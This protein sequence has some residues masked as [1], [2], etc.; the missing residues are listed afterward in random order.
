[1]EGES[2]VQGVQAD[3]ETYSHQRQREIPSLPAGTRTMSISELRWKIV[4]LIWASGFPRK[5]T[6][7]ALAL[8]CKSFMGPALDLLWREL[9]ELN[10]LIRCLPP[11]LWKI[12]KQE[13]VS[14]LALAQ[15]HSNLLSTE[16]PKGH[17]A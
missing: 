11:S 12:D 10:P 3:C 15:E 9:D 8:T 6:L 4:E 16:I 2:F 13:L 1:M 7:L 17:D 5:K 14:R